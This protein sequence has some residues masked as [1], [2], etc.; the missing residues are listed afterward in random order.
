MEELQG[1]EAVVMM[2]KRHIDRLYN[3]YMAAMGI[4]PVRLDDEDVKRIDILVRR[5]SYRS[6]NEAIRKM[7]KAM[8]LESMTEDEDIDGLVESMLRLKKTGREPVV[9]RLKKTAV[10][11]VAHGR[12]RWPT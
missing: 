2:R 10:E 5:Q 6:R 7:V 12:D 4:I 9:L 11:L 3:L 1:L 8:L